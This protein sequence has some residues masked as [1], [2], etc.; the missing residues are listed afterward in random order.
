MVSLPCLQKDTSD[1]ELKVICSAA[2]GGYAL[3]FGRIDDGVLRFSRSAGRERRGSS[4]LLRLWRLCH[5]ESSPSFLGLVLLLP[6]GCSIGYMALILPSEFKGAYHDPYLSIAE[7]VCGVQLSRQLRRN[8]FDPQRPARRARRPAAHGR[9]AGEAGMIPCAELPRP[10]LRVGVLAA[11]AHR[12]P[13][14]HAEK[15]NVSRR[16]LTRKRL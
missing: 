16:P 15:P 7:W 3:R 1:L 11:A 5:C 10:L 8:P 14:R 6:G 13:D 12:Q 2:I 9:P 4:P